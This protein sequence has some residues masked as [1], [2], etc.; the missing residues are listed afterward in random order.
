[1][2]TKM[3]VGYAKPWTSYAQQLHI[4]QQRGMQVSDPAK[5]LEYLERIGYYRLSGYWYDM[6]LWQRDA[7]N[8]RVVLDNFK[9]GTQFQDVAALYVFDKRLRLLTLDALER[10]EV[11]VRVDLSY[12]LGQ[13]GAFAYRDPMQFHPN[14]VH[15]VQPR[16]GL[17][18]HNDWLNNQEYLI[19]RS[20]EKFIEHYRSKYGLPLAIWVACE[21]WDFG[22]MSILFS[23]LPTAEQD[24]IAK[25]Y[26]LPESHGQMFATWLRSLNY[27]RNVS[28]HHSRLWNR[29]VVDQPKLPK[30]IPLHTSRG[31]RVSHGSRER[32]LLILL[33]PQ[34]L[35]DFSTFAPKLL[36]HKGSRTCV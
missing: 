17:T 30:R 34:V 21:V 20:R 19:R 2:T 11:A 7:R 5:A 6:R 31:V 33:T 14:F 25:G 16:S 36:I 23:G 4:L 3:M 35:P 13:K 22:C 8:K 29:N 18:K 9:P 26:G 10:I 15:R 12:R 27:L 1:M 32:K 24:A 28:A